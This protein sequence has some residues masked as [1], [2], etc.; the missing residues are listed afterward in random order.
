M[1]RNSSES[2]GRPK[3]TE[4]EKSVKQTKENEKEPKK[5]SL[6]D[7]IFIYAFLGVILTEYASVI[8]WKYS[9]VHFY[10]IFWYPILG[11]LIVMLLI[12]PNL[13]NARKL[14]FCLAKKLA[15]WSLFGYYAMNILTIIFNCQDVLYTTLV[16]NLFLG[17]AFSM[18]V[19]TIIKNEK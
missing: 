13:I 19:L 10:T 15:F 16:N 14:K 9:E 2:L 11:N 17:L 7:N 12:L 4:E 1:P 18:S 3:I 5:K 6:A 8:I